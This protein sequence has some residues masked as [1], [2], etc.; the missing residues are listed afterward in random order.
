MTRDRKQFLTL[1]KNESSV[2]FG[3]NGTSKIV[4]K[5]TLSLD[6]GRNKTETIL[7]IEDL[8]YNLLIVS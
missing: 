2:T 5:G 8:K 4:G 7:C 3:N 6:N 1:K